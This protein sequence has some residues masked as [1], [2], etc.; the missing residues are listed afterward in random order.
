MRVRIGLTRGLV[1]WTLFMI[2]A[3]ILLVG[4]AIWSLYAGQQALLLQL[5][6]GALPE[7]RR[8]GPHP[9]HLRLLRP[10]RTVARRTCLRPPEVL[11]APSERLDPIGHEPFNF[12]LDFCR[13]TYTLIEQ[14]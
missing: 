1:L 12:G 3:A 2:L 13:L 6:A 10:A 8:S 14:K 4:Q 5:S 9:A 11:K 7:Q